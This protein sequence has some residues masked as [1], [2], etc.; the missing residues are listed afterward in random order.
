M[1][2]N[3]VPHFGSGSTDLGTG[4]PRHGTA[5][6]AVGWKWCSDSDFRC[7]GTARGQGSRGRGLLDAY[8]LVSSQ[9]PTI[10]RPLYFVPS[11]VEECSESRFWLSW[12]SLLSWARPMHT[13][14]RRLLQTTKKDSLYLSTAAWKAGVRK[15]DGSM[16]QEAG[17]L[18]VDQLLPGG[19]V[20]LKARAIAL[21]GLFAPESSKLFQNK[22]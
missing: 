8:P 18:A 3:H 5:A 15:F 22:Q 11:M 6:D 7:F 13:D 9:C 14:L 4:P 21:P 10:P 19:I 16:P 12:F 1:C 2:S 20:N 17:L